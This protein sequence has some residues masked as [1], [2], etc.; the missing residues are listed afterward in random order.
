MRPVRI[1]GIIHDPYSKAEGRAPSEWMA[2]LA[3]GRWAALTERRYYAVD[4]GMDQRSQR[5]EP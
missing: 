3:D 1:R 4:R 5:S 2:E